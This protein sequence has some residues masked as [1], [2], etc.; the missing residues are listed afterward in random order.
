MPNQFNHSKALLVLLSFAALQFSIPGDYTM[1]ANRYQHLLPCYCASK[2]LKISF[3]KQKDE[4]VFAALNLYLDFVN[5]FIYI[6]RIIS[7]RRD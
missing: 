5:L 7:S 2:G 4:Y 1:S 3:L 6:L